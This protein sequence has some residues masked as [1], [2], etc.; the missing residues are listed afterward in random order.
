MQSLKSRLEDLFPIKARY[1]Y[2]LSAASGPLPRATQ[3]KLESFSRMLCH[4]SCTA[5]DI[6]LD[7]L[8][9]T[10]TSAARLL[11][12][13]ED[14]VAF[15]K[16]TGTGLWIASRAIDWK[17]GDEI[18]LPRGEFPSNIIPWVSLEEKGVRVKWL[19][20]EEPG[21]AR[22]R[23]TPDAV[24][25]LISPRTRA[26]AV[27]FVQFDDGTRRDVNAIGDLCKENGI[28]YVV[29]AIQGLGALPFSVRECK[30]DFVATG[31]QK[32]LLSAPGAGLLYV[33]PEQLEK[34]TVPNLGW[35][36]VSD[37]FKLDIESLESL[38]DR[39]LPTARRFEEGTPNFP[40][41]AALGASIDVLLGEGIENIAQRIK[42]LTDRL[43]DGIS[44]IDC[45]LI[46]PR[47]ESTWSGIV[48]FKHNA[49][50]ADSLNKQLLENS[51]VT[52]VRD[53]WLRV[54]VHFFNDEDEI[55]R[56]LSTVE[57]ARAN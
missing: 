27:S 29:D 13:H 2:F 37:P 45:E 31:S 7:A 38:K 6:W 50:D 26:L 11:D 52:S 40:G 15:V 5:F 22:P 23:V 49:I 39:L 30:A 35:L 56:L 47:D 14:N 3:E 12:C 16:N 1:A 33:S 18:I 8:D 48:S 41:I 42:I 57:N 9:S 44:Q 46:S 4:E 55:Q 51:I 20:P 10:R 19:N 17:E 36:S 25:A 34:R 24:R 32:W 43:C 21:S 53:E 28:T 54:A